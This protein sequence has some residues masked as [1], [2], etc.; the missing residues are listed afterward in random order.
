M[1]R[2]D[3]VELPGGTGWGKEGAV[4]EAGKSLDSTRKGSRGHVEMIVGIR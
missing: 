2:V 1:L 3:S 4:E